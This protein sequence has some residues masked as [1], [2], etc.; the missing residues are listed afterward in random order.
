MVEAV[1]GKYK[2]S[3][4]MTGLEMEVKADGTANIVSTMMYMTVLNA[5]DV[6]YV[7][8]QD[9]LVME[10]NAEKLQPALDEMM[11]IPMITSTYG[12]VEPSGVCPKYQPNGRDGNGKPAI[13]ITVN[14]TSGNKI[15]SVT[16]TLV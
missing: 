8:N 1:T 3:A 15:L 6:P 12:T 4:G 13:W 11:K 2:G 10:L 7:L 9:T 14:S 5:Q 16:A